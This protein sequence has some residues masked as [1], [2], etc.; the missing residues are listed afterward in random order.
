MLSLNSYVQADLEEEKKQENLKFLNSLEAMQKKL[1]EATAVA[2]KEREAARKA[3]DEA[4]AVVEE[5]KIV[6]EDTKKVE[7][8][9]IEVGDLKVRHLMVFP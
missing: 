1:D 7:S 8:L 2:V 5:K 4:P 9:T 6:I 3:I